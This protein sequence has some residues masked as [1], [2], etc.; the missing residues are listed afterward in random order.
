MFY[1]ELLDKYKLINFPVNYLEVMKIDKHISWYLADSTNQFISVSKTQN[2]NILEV[3]IKQAFTSICNCLFPTDSKFIQKMNTI[4]DKKSR[5]IFIATQLVNTEYLKK[6]NIISK[7]IILGLIF[8]LDHTV[9]LLELKKDGVIICCNDETFYKLSN[10][11]KNPSSS[12]IE[13][14]LSKKISIHITEFHKYVRSN[15]TSYL[16]GN[17]LVVKGIY[18]HFPPFLLQLQN[19]IINNESIGVDEL[20]KIYSFNYFKI[21]FNN[22]LNELLNQYYICNNQRVINSDGKYVKSPSET[23]PEYYLK[24]F[25]YPLILSNKL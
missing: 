15:R 4:T 11:E 8:D 21:V 7:L 17:T 6:L 12:F 24:L 13:Y 2:L 1:T 23:D 10:I 22:H 3:D 5:N 14:I 20:L 19:M 9:T 18:K 16:C 25:I